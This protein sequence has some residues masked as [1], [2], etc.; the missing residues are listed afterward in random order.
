MLPVSVTYHLMCA[1]LNHVHIPKF[2][3]TAVPV[4][5]MS[6][7]IE[8]FTHGMCNERASSLVLIVVSYRDIGVVKSGK[9]DW[10]IILKTSLIISHIIL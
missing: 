9:A 2:N 10:G 7:T 6:K 3:T 4:A 8:I 5:S 1:K